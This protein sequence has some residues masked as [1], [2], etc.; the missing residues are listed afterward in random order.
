MR[1]KVNYFGKH[2]DN[3]SESSMANCNGRLSA[4]FEFVSDYSGSFDLFTDDTL[5]P[6]NIY[7]AAT[8]PH[9]HPRAFWIQEVRPLRENLYRVIEKDIEKFMRHFSFDY[10]YTL[11]RDFAELHPNF[12]FLVGNGTFIKKPGLFEKSKCC[13]MITSTKA[14]TDA[15]K[16]RLAYAKKFYSHLDLYGRGINPVNFK[17]EALNP[18]MFSVAIENTFSRSTFTEKLLDCFLTGTVPVYLGASDLVDFFDCNGIIPLSEDFNLSDLNQDLYNKMYSSVVRNYYTAL[19][20]MMPIENAL[21]QS[22]TLP[23]HYPAIYNY[24]NSISKLS[25][26]NE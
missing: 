17:S 18:Y 9:V 12:I 25:L 11:D 16:I 26:R 22:I 4:L 2:S 3:K 21:Y 23:S 7:Q 24:R 14:F 1:V 5:S 20:L 8:I 10:I 13:S 6:D 15:Q 19:D